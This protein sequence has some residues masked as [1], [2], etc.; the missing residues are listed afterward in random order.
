MMLAVIK[1]KFTEVHENQELP[2]T[3][4]K[5]S[6]SHSHDDEDSEDEDVPFYYTVQ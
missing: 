4:K 5:K 6:H 1:A 2:Q 3:N